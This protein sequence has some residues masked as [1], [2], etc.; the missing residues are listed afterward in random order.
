MT[1]SIAGIPSISSIGAPGQMP[2]F[3]LANFDHTDPANYFYRGLFEENQKAKG[4]DWQGRVDFTY[5]LTSP[6]P[7]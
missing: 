2:T 1:S 6:L 7:V 5:Q 3:N 4:K